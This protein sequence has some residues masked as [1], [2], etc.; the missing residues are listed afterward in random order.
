[1]SDDNVIKEK[2][3][4]LKMCM[5]EELNR[6]KGKIIQENAPNEKEC[7]CFQLVESSSRHCY[8]K[9]R[10][11]YRIRRRQAFSRKYKV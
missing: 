11:S 6:L 1:M 4:Y 7:S 2:L 9:H 3:E 5:Y 8:L 10:K